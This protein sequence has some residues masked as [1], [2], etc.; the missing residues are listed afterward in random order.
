M[1]HVVCQFVI[2]V[3]VSDD[4]TGFLGVGKARL[5]QALVRGEVEWALP[6]LIHLVAGQVAWVW[7]RRVANDAIV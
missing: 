4:R 2:I 5:T 7:N 3:D 6:V 1:F